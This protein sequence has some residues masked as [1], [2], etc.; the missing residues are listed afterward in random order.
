[1]NRGSLSHASRTILLARIAHLLTV[2]ARSTY[3]PGTENL[4][5]PTV[6]RAY[7]EL[8]HRV[9]ASVVAHVEGD[10]SFP[11]EAITQMLHEFGDR[12]NRKDE[13][14]WLLQTVQ[15]RPLPKEN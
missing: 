2:C 1:M 10:E 7:N 13:I 5:E 12:F 3:E 9:A 4:K 15:E 11:L 6:L 8:L 14:T